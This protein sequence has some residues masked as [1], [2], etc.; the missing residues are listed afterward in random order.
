M[1]LLSCTQVLIVPMSRISPAASQ[2]RVPADWSSMDGMVALVACGG[3]WVPAS[4]QQMEAIK[5]GQ[6]ACECQQLFEP[7]RTGAV[8]EYEYVIMGGG[9]NKRYIKN[10]YTGKC[11]AVLVVCKPEVWDEPINHPPRG[12]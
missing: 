10:V 8:G 11:R 9:S 3:K 6:S 12:F 1:G 5:K 7:Y 2:A 4:P